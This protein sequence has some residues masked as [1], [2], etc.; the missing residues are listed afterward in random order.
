MLSY[1][2]QQS[3]SHYNHVIIGSGIT[4]LSH[5]VEL[6]DRFPDWRILVL[7]RGLLPT[8]ASTKNAGF[9]CMGS[10]TEILDDLET[11]T[12][13]EVLTLFAARKS[14]LQ[15]LRER[16]GDD[17][18]R[19]K[20]EGSFELIG[21]QEL[22][23]IER[24]DYLNDLLS[25]VVG[26]PAFSVDS[27][28]MQ[29][30]GFGGSYAAAM[31]ENLCE[32][33]IDTGFMMRALIGMAQSKGVEIRTGAAVSRFEERASGVDVLVKSALIGDDLKLTCEHLSICTN[34]YTKA[35]LPDEDIVPGRG[36]VL[37]T[38]PVE[39]LRFKGVFHFD[40]GYY[41]FREIDG[42]VL[43]GGGRNLDF[44]GEQT[45]DM[46][47][48][49]LIQ[50]DLEQKL[51]EVILQGCRYKI[52]QRWSGVMAFGETKQPIVKA[53]SERIFGAFRL[54]GMGVAMGSN[55]AADLAE[56]VAERA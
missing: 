27:T 6:K 28:S 22:Y 24:L 11:M 4:G 2:E 52:S 23:A 18:I 8:G 9:A 48:S 21:N 29:Q 5:A 12:E 38:E 39:G 53:V 46:S 33:S 55:V 51:R 31:I 43:L 47:L 54:G 20:A 1:W 32:G 16:L 25:P 49:E 3:F 17:A 45:T 36:Q 26:G 15:K 50:A 42:R 44:G 10:A 34:A 56:L 30:F 37:V 41:Y 7:E 40:K 14:G 35:L 13:T 19:Y